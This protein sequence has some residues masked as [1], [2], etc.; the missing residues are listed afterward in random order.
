MSSRTTR[1]GTR[2][3]VL[4]ALAVLPGCGF[5]LQRPATLPES[6]K[7][8]HI[9]AE[10][11]QSDFYHA[12]KTQ[13]EKAGVD[14]DANASGAAVLRI[15]G[16]GTSERVLSVSARNVP[17]EYELRY[18]VRVAVDAGGRELLPAEEFSL[19]RDYSFDETTL[20]AKERERDMLSD[21]LASE[22]AFVVLRRL[23][24]L[25]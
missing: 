17:T 19:T 21:A 25:E 15:L 20:L 10:D 23:A 3:A 24:S 7:T 5:H 18:A 22:L 8:L 4:F 11:T 12:L 9:V 6:L 13:L 1:A 16:D 14:P 2:I